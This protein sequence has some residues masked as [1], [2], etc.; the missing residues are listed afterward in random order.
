M[1]ADRFQGLYVRGVEFDGAG[2]RDFGLEEGL[3]ILRPG[4]GDGVKG[5]G[6]AMP[7]PGGHTKAEGD[8]SDPIAFL[9]LLLLVQHPVQLA[10]GRL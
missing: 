5:D 3:G 8:E 10:I 7:I 4:H 2:D 6:H 9:V 1:D